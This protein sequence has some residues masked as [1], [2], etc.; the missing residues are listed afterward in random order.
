MG[1]QAG[2]GQRGVHPHRLPRHQGV[3]RQGRRRAPGVPRGHLGLP[4]D[5]QAGGEPGAGAGGAHLGQDPG[6][7]GGGAL[8]PRGPFHR[9][10]PDRRPQ[11]RGADLR[12]GAGPEP[13]RGQ[14]GERPAELRG[15]QDPGRAARE[16]RRVRARDP[17]QCDREL[18]RER[19]RPRGGH[20]RRPRAVRAR[21]LQD[22]QR[23]RCGRTQDHHRNHLERA[24]DRPQHREAD[25][26][27]DSPARSRCPA[28]ASRDRAPGGVRPCPAG[29]GGRERAGPPG[30]PEADLRARPADGGREQ[31]D[32]QRDGPRADA[33]RARPRDYRGSPAA[34]GG[35]HREGSCHRAKPAGPRHRPHR[36]GERA[37]AH[38]RAAQ[39]RPGEGP[40]GPPD[41]AQSRSRG[42]RRSR[43]SPVDSRARA[44]RR[45]ATSSSRPRS[46]SA[47]APTSSGSPR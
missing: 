9:R 5:D 42:R 12:R 33:H 4:R 2:A 6:R 8:R 44:R 31:G 32:R 13:P 25:H 22:R 40:E 46:A 39:P 47:S 20:D 24:P 36:E 29:S 37:G 26:G 18:Q 19:A 41:R 17:D 1:L 27:R 16:P 34:R 30:R 21:V 38:R 15:D 28:R 43:I 14:G 7:R 35:R 11:P 23:V 3:S 45:T 10:P